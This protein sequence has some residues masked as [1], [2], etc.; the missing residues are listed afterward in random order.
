MKYINF[1]K[2]QVI[3]ELAMVIA[4]VTIIGVFAKDGGLEDAVKQLFGPAAKVLAAVDHLGNYD[5]PAA[6]N[7]IKQ[8]QQTSITDNGH[9]GYENET[10]KR[11]TP[12]GTPIAN[13]HN[14]VYYKR[15]MIRSGWVDKYEDDAA[16]PEIKGLYDDLG[17][18][19]WS[20]L[21]GS[22]Q[23]YRTKVTDNLT[24]DAG[25]YIGDV[26]LYWTVEDLSKHVITSYSTSEKSNYSKQLILQYFYSEKTEKYYVIK[27]Y[28][29]VN[30]NDVANHIALG[31]LHQQYK[32]PAGYFVDG[33][34]EG[35]DNFADAKELFEQVRR[36]NGYSVVFNKDDIEGDTYAGNWVLEGKKFVLK[37]N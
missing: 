4:F 3:V 14:S 17:A 21:N 1:R 5:L 7:A 15:G 19:Q 25:V 10:G 27:S 11:K 37:E 8:L 13:S 9:Y 32:K 30:Q 35:F 29:W 34:T 28:V 20:Y 2:G 18:S 16:L 26:G 24:Q 23:N 6:V 12:D 36:D 22:G 33:C 31:G